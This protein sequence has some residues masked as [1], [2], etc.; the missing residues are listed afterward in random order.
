MKS[1]NPK[2]TEASNKLKTIFDDLLK[3]KSSTKI[4]NE[5]FIEALAIATINT[6]NELKD[7]MGIA[8]LQTFVYD[9]QDFINSEIYEAGLAKEDNAEKSQKAQNATPTSKP[10][11]SNEILLA[12]DSIFSRMG[13]SVTEGT[14]TNLQRQVIL[15]KIYTTHLPQMT[16]EEALRWGEPASEQRLEA[17]ARFLY[18]LH[19]FQGTEKPSART[20][21]AEDLSWLKVKYYQNSMNFSWPIANT[22][23]TI[24][25][26]ARTPIS[27]YMKAL[28]P[29]KELAEVVGQKSLPRTEVISKIWEYIKKNG[30]QNNT[31]KRLIDCDDKLFAIFDKKEVSMFELAARIGKHL[32]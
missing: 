19:S 22:T 30:L 15:I 21:W 1:K 29:S 7:G 10:G 17:M 6:S 25:P 24:K 26:K 23:K 4:T 14:H 28:Q 12:Q 2:T 32:H 11:H 5:Q 27:A 20:K 18:W 16:S 9:L 13:Y 31:N 3:P 8:M